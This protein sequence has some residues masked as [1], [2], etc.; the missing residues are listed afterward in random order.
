MSA[1]TRPADPR[2]TSTLQKRASLL[3]KPSTITLH[4]TALI[5]QHAQLTGTYPITIGPAAVLHPHCKLS[6]AQAPLVLG[7]GVIVYERAK[8]G[9][10]MGEAV[11]IA[12][13]GGGGVES[14]RASGIE[15]RRGEGTL[16]GKNVVVETR[17]VVEAAEVGEG[18]VVEVGAYLGPGSVVGKFCTVGA[19]CV[20]PANTQLPD[21]TV[22]YGVTERRVD[23]TLQSRP[24]VQEMRTAFHAKQLDTFRKLLPNNIAKWT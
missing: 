12:K 13:G 4:P 11:D 9:V 22:L 8:V 16:L 19:H 17:A 21:Y 1:P 5:A 6:S 23:K 24:E 3:P 14:R 15:G 10:G 7:P 20:V 2:R 18:S